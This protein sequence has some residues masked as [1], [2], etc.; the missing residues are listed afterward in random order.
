MD[1][2]TARLNVHLDST[3]IDEIIYMMTHKWNLTCGL[4]LYFN[5]RYMYDSKKTLS[6]YKIGKDDTLHIFMSGCAK[7]PDKIELCSFQTSQLR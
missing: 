2:T 7:L 4:K 5:G 6:D 1:N 3:N